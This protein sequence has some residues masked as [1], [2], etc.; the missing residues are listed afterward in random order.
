MREYNITPLTRLAENF[1]KL[2]GIGKKT[3][4][5]L[6]YSVLKMSDA[7]TENFA[8]SILDAKK[9][10]HYCKECCNFT[11]KEV[12]S[13][14]ENPKRDRSIICVVEDP[15]DVEAFE[16]TKEFTSI[17]HVLHGVISPL[18]GVGPEQICIK[19]LLARVKDGN[20]KE[21]IMASNPTVEGEATAMYVS[22]ILKPFEVK[23]TRL[24]YG[25]PVGASLE[26]ADE[27]TLTRALQG[28]S[29]I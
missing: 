29:E 22:K 14:C 10:I 1:G 20:V 7:E 6:A 13:I 11:D 4:Y 19:E 25:V 28:R 8:S 27:V 18:N 15:K 21:V 24:A 9:K 12:C 3:A 23:V 26:Y 2:P 17:Y 16:R 5:R